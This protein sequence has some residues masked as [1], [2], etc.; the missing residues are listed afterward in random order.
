MET[1]TK[2]VHCPGCT[3]PTKVRWETAGTNAAGWGERAGWWGC[4]KHCGWHGQVT[5]RAAAPKETK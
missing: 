1:E 5:L 3:R 2:R 4:C